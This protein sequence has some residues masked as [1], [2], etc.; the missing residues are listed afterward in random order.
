MG[1]ITFECALVV[2]ITVDVEVEGEG[3]EGEVQAQA[4]ALESEARREWDVV[5][6]SCA[7]ALQRHLLLTNRAVGLSVLRSVSGELPELLVQV[8]PEDGG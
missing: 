4:A 5:S 2:D 8:T 6:D 7:R 1:R 3:R